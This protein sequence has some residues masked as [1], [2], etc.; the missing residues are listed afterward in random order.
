MVVGDAC[1]DKEGSKEEGGYYNSRSGRHQNI[2]LRHS[3][4]LITNS[5]RHQTIV[6]VS[7]QSR[8]CRS[9]VHKE[10]EEGF[11]GRHVG[12]REQDAD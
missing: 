1:I 3:F 5:D 11:H 12:D 7:K 2:S 9:Q 6:V 4:R 8:S 10:V